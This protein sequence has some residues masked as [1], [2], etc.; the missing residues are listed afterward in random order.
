MDRKIR[1]ELQAVAARLEEQ[2]HR[3]GELWILELEQQVWAV[4]RR[5]RA[6]SRGNPAVM[7]ASGEIDGR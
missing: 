5:C 6:L 1:E 7:V 2:Y 3:S 4:V